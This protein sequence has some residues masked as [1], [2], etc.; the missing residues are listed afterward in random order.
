MLNALSVLIRKVYGQFSRVEGQRKASNLILKWLQ[1]REFPKELAALE[2]RQEII[3]TSPL[4]DLSPML[5]TVG[6]MRVGGRCN[7]SRILCEDERHPIILPKRA[8]VVQVIIR[9]VHEKTNHGGRGFTL[10]EMRAQGFYILKGSK[11]IAQTI[12]DC[13]VCRKQRRPAESQKMADLPPERTEMQP[14]FYNSGMDV[15]GPF[16]I[17]RGRSEIKRYGLL[18]TCL[19]SRAI[20]VELLDDLSAD[21][22]LNALRCFLVLRGV[23]KTI[24]CDQG[25]NFIGGS[26]ELKQAMTELNNEALQVFL[27]KKQIELKFNV[28][29]AS[30]QGGVWERQIRTVRNVLKSVIE[31]SN[32]RLDDSSLRTLFYEATYIVNSRPL[33]PMSLNDPLSDPPIT[34]NALLHGKIE[35]VLPP[36]G[37]FCPRDVYARK[38][39]RRVQYLCDIF[40]SKWKK[41]YLLHLQQRRKWQQPKRN[42]REGDIVLLVEKTLPRNQWPMGII[43]SAP[44]D[45]DGLVRKVRIKTSNAPNI[46]RG[47]K[48]TQISN[49][50]RP[51]Q[52]IVLL[53]PTQLPEIKD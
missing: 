12:H 18:F 15:F 2:R 28:P 10:N 52:N 48:V 3:S 1:R 5:D 32:A 33:S 21:C 4:K 11:V 23:V 49:L 29:H 38:R 19:Y 35:G 53:L 46:A 6:L 25:S 44:K 9:H 26:N 40:W 24:F 22:F 43:T 8:H 31:F 36:P 51:V 14:V 41:E 30:E 20:H 16:M 34:P 13:F 27:A 42:L 45:K 17:K 50:Q 37:T 7:L 39:W 47:T